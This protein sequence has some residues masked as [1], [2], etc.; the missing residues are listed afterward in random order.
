MP[1][2]TQQASPRQL[3]HS[4]LCFGAAE[5]MNFLG[6]KLTGRFEGEGVSDLSSFA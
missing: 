3:S 2:P 4:T 1:T 6:R 5:V